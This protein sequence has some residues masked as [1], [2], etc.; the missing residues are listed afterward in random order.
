MKS[1][2]SIV[3]EEGSS[4][5]A[6][7]N[8]F[9]NLTRNLLATHH[10][11]IRGNINFSGME[12]DLV[13]THKHT[14]ELL[15]VECK[16]KQKVSADEIGK[17]SFNVDFKEANKGYFFR[18]KEL[19]YQ[20]GALLSEM[21]T[22]EK[23]KNLFFFEPNDII[24]MLID[25]KMIF[26]PQ[27]QLSNFSF[28]KRI[29]AIT[30]FGDF[31][32]YLV[33]E[34]NALPTKFLVVNA[35][36]NDKPISDINL[37]ILREHI[38]DIKT[39][40]PITNFNN[41]KKD[42]ERNQIIEAIA[43]VQESENWYDYLPASAEKKHFVGR[44][45]IRTKVLSF[46]KDVHKGKSK[47][48]IFYLNGKSGWG[49]SSL[50]LEIKDR[51]RNKHYKN[52]FFSIAID[53]RSAI[54]DNFIA[55]SLNKL[56]DDAISEKFLSRN[57]FFEDI[58]F[59]S[60][61]DLLS[62]KSM[63]QLLNELK[64]EKKFLV[65]I[66]DQFEDV[67]RKKDFFKSFYK[68]ISDV[69]DKQPNLI[70]GFS[71]KSDFLIQPDD[72]AYHIWQQSKEQARAFAVDEFGEKEIDGIIRQLE[73]SVGELD[74]SIKNRIKESSQ[75][76]PWLTKKLCIHIF[77]Q[78]ETGLG[79]ENLIES[80]LNI[81]D[82]FKRDEERIVSD[83]LKGLKIIARRAYNGNFFDETDV[84]DII[85]EKIILSL[86]NK[87]L[88]I[89]S[90]ANYNIYWD[91]FRDYLVTGIVPLIGESY[92]LRQMVNSCLDVFLLF[93]NTSKKE[94]LSSLVE[95]HHRKIG[96]DAL[97][98]ILIE[99][100]NIGLVKKVNDYFIPIENVVIT[101]EGFIDY[102]TGKFQNYTP[103]LILKKRDYSK[104]TKDKIIEIL[105]D[106]FK[107]DFQDVT[108]N[109][110]ANTLLSWFLMSNLDIKDRIVEPSRGRGEPTVLTDEEYNLYLPKCSLKEIVEIIPLYMNDLDSLNRKFYKD[111][112]L[113]EIIDKNK[114]VTE[115]GFEIVS[116]E[117][118][119]IEKL[120]KERMSKVPKISIL[121]EEYEKDSSLTSSRIVDK[122]PNNFFNG[123]KRSSKMIYAGRALTWVK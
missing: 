6:K 90:G 40:K 39:L 107:Q 102:I 70:I 108:W 84:G 94:S 113:L 1:E 22:K 101:E 59:T 95:R 26:E 18:T 30:Y 92:L 71:W 93:Q 68:F 8:C 56:I 64:A 46:F 16:A 111:L 57:I 34:S 67:F 19:E 54:S 38:P 43:E 58:K 97:Y 5:K 87:R 33:N 24:K 17:F 21:R 28:S 50:V 77:N 96:E 114:N 109:A 51:C 2:I 83:E 66:F 32:V 3:L 35:K 25:A 55:L 112:F 91:I 103:Y 116:F 10:Y 41:Y 48:R 81:L 110:Y 60:N 73:N 13:A 117:S 99:L 29:L 14:G 76:L 104:I 88:I 78:I 31:F 69:T 115:F 42:K 20:A 9:E 120:L 15:Y 53:T 63:L 27:A 12:I 119:K 7:G 105:K 100:R 11:D 75:G 61:V 123:T 82:L 89:R 37:D 52:K 80:N 4:N 79:K 36:E 74:N 47:K 122:M 98:N 23:Y 44:S 65:L 86:L 72:D 45:K 106:T 62:S 118:K 49:K 85:S 121:K